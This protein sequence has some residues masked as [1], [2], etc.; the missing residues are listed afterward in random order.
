VYWL[1]SSSKLTYFLLNL[2]SGPSFIWQISLVTSCRLAYCINLSHSSDRT[3][4]HAR[5]GVETVN[6]KLCLSDKIT[7]CIRKVAMSRLELRPWSSLLRFLVVFLRFSRQMPRFNYIRPR[8]PY[9][10]NPPPLYS[11]ILTFDALKCRL[12]KASL[13]RLQTNKQLQAFP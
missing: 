10:N 5:G 12:L 9:Y 4:A 11:L 6:V 2:F 8:P 13:N 7:L 3:R 1:R